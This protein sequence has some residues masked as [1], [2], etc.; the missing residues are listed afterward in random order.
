[1]WAVTMQAGD[2]AWLVLLSDEPVARFPRTRE[3][4]D[5]ACRFWAILRRVVWESQ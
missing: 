2:G 4:F 5:R 3:G 1:M